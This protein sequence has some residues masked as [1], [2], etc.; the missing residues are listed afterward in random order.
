MRAATRQL[1]LVIHTWGGSRRRA[2]RKP[3]VAGHPVRHY[4][5]PVHEARCPVH[6]TLRAAPGVPSLRGGVAFA[7]I[8]AAFS[9]ASRPNFRLLHFSVQTTHLH[10]LVEAD[11]STAFRSGIQGLA[12]RVARAINRAF[13]RRGKVWRERYHAHMLQTPR[14]TRNALV[15]VLQNFMKHLPR[16]RGV[17]PRSSGPWFS[18]WRKSS[19]AAPG[20]SPV[21]A[22]RTWLAT[23]G[24]K[25]H[26]LI[27]VDEQPRSAPG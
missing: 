22:G 15:Y 9:L 20:P 8:R 14:E 10:L 23:V 11:G 16:A 6:V 26:G 19:G 2:G 12:I 18:G 1:E 13:G 27:G 25:R 5:R 21:V 17:D 4:R 7:V 24:W 3:K